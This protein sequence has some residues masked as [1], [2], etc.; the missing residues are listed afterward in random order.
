MIAVN[1]ENINHYFDLLQEIF[2]EHN[3]YGHPEAIAITWMKLACLL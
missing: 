1:K 2:N 3:F